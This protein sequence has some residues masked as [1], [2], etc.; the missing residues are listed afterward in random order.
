[1]DTDK[2]ILFKLKDQTFAVHVQQIVSI[3]RELS[4]TKVPR[5][6][7][8]MMGVTEMRGIMTPMIDLRERLNLGGV[9]ITDQTRTLVVQVDDM[10]IG[11]LVDQATEVKDIP[12]SF[13]KPAPKLVGEIK[14]TFLLGVATID[15]ELILLLDL[16]QIIQFTEK[17]QLQE[18]MDELD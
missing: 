4:L 11:M 10:Q 14:D 8:F 1:M 12:A 18:V 5:T 15:D 13:I 17:N 6:P 16:E 2:H 3:E 9:E 7:D